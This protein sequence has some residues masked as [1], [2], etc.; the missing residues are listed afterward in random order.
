MNQ[1]DDVKRELMRVGLSLFQRG[2]T[3]GASANI[4]AAY[5]DGYVVTPTNSCIGFLAFDELSVLNKKGEL[6]GGKP[7]SK[8]FLLHQTFYDQQPNVGSV[9]HLHSTYATAVSCL[10]PEDENDVIPAI[11]PYLRMR[12]GP[13]CRV[14]FYAPGAVELVQAVAERAAN[15]KGVLM[16]N[17]GPI[18]A[19]DN[20]E[21]AMY[22]MEEL[23]ESAK[24]QLLLAQLPANK[25]SAEHVQF[26]ETGYKGKL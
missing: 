21:K 15:F 14:P 26:L 22:A 8:E 10:T 11:T 2:L 9:I 12:L 3:P 6:I 23:E 25:L 20:L 13:I 16:A 19:S 4:S 5:R 1:L 17:H 24:L 7:P 18:V